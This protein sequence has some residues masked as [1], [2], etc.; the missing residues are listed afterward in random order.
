M[1]GKK[2]WKE[3]SKRQLFF[4]SASFIHFFH[5]FFF[6]LYG[7][8]HSIWKFLGQGLNP[9]HSC[10]LWCS[11]GNASS[12]NPMPWAGN[13]TCTSIATWATQSYFFQYNDFFSI[14]AGLQCSVDFLLYSMVTQLHIYVY[15]LFSHIIILH[16]KW[17]DIVP[18]ATQQDLTPKG[19]L[20]QS[21]T[22]E[23]LVLYFTC[24]L[25]HRWLDPSLLR[26]PR[27]WPICFGRR[28]KSQSTQLKCPKHVT[29][30]IC[31]ISFYLKSIFFQEKKN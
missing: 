12:F 28:Y 29:F 30:S 10:N 31:Y 15:I 19:F 22:W 21:T 25:W 23:L 24:L 6:S 4:L 5:L 1:R 13:W 18:S 16:H 11:C 27:G 2:T 14:T 8:T 26:I 7:R 20:I 17:L 9:G 3:N